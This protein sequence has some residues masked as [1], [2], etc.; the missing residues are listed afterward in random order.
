LRREVL[1]VEHIERDEGLLTIL[2]SVS[3]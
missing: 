2:L 1:D 3:I